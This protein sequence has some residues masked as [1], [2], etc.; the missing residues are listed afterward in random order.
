M[1]VT[2]FADEVFPEEG[3][4]VISCSFTDEDGNAVTPDSIAWTLTKRK[5]YQGDTASIIN[6]REGVSETPASTIYIV[7][8][9]DDLALLTA[10]A[11]EAFVERVLS[12]SYV[13]DSTYGN[14]LTNKAQ[15][16]F[17]IENADYVT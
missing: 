11:E 8:T 7:L 6:S 3:T 13:Y 1:A 16:V 9:G 12:V 4:R 5:K 10:E 15:Y 2:T 17:R 14:N